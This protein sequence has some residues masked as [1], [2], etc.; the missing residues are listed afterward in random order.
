MTV[1]HWASKYGY[2]RVVKALLESGAPVNALDLRGFSALMHASQFGHIEVVQCLLTHKA[3]LHFKSERQTAF[4]LAAVFNRPTVLTIFLRLGTTVD[5]QHWW[6]LLHAAFNG[7]FHISRLLLEN[8]VDANFQL[9]LHDE[10][11]LFT[12]RYIGRTALYLAVYNQHADLVGLLVKNGANI[13][14]VDAYGETVFGYLTPK[15]PHL[16]SA[17]ERCLY[18]LCR[19]SWWRR[20]HWKSCRVANAI[21]DILFRFFRLVALALAGIFNPS[22]RSRRPS[23][24]SA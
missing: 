16:S 5:R 4:T 15:W 19:R 17:E 7:L 8:R 3:F 23:S 6:T 14:A 10:A 9:T 1:L 20:M 18:E 11:P 22:S 12:W 24:V 21:A 13:N 2:I